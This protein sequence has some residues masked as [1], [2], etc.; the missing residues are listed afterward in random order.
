MYQFWRA[1]NKM[2][3]IIVIY[4]RKKVKMIQKLRE[5]KQMKRIIHKVELVLHR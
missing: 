4:V 5:K 2:K 3:I 1:Q